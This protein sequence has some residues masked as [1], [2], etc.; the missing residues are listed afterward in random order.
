MARLDLKI[1]ATLFLALFTVVTGVGIVVPLLPV[2]AH[3]L[4]AGG[5]YIGLIFGAF[6]LSRTLLLPYFGRWSDRRGRRPFIVVGLAAYALISLAFMV[7]QTVGGLIAIRFVQGIASAMMMPVIQAYVGDIT[8]QGREGSTMG[9]F[10]MAMFLGLSLGPVL[11]GLINDR[12]SLH[13]AFGAMGLLSLVSF[14]LALALLPPTAREQA[15]Q[16]PRAP[17]A[18]RR[19]MGDRGIA[20]LFLFRWAYASCIGIMWGFVPVLADRDFGMSSAAIGILV[21]LGVLISGLMHLPMGLAADRMGKRRLM[22]GGGILIG[23]GMLLFYTAAS[24]EALVWA[25]ILL[26]M[27][28]GVS[29]P[30]LMALAVVKGSRTDAMG[31]VMSLITMAHSLGMLCGSLIAGI[32]MDLVTLRWAFPVGAI[33]MAAASL[34][35]LLVP[36]RAARVPVSSLPPPI[37]P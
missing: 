34:F 18:W 13:W 23:G 1:F 21:M 26:G 33:L 7:S 37:E 19:L 11:G 30:A 32:L 6:S 12:F 20:G 8:P 35:L 29:M 22:I 16:R 9:L 24:P 14:L 2:Y 15:M 36:D 4:G 27:G 31:S 3:S 10:N 17:I 25:S 5:F 28:G